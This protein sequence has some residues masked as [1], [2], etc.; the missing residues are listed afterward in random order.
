MKLINGKTVFVFDNEGRTAD[1]YTIVDSLTNVF[2]CSVDPFWPQGIAMYCFTGT[3]DSERYFR[4]QGKEMP[5]YVIKN[6][7]SEILRGF[8]GRGLDSENAIGKEI[9]KFDSL[10]P[11]VQKYILQVT[12]Q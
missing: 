8:R 5:K 6:K 4:D 7:L 3:D 12:E 1:R 2:G 11:D 9:K 10:P